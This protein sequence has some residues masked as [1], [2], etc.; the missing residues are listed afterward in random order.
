V[1]MRRDRWSLD[2]FDDL[3]G[4]VSASPSPTLPVPA[5]ARAVT[6]VAESASYA[7]SRRAEAPLAYL[8]PV[9]ALPAV[10]ELQITVET[11][12]SPPPA[13]HVALR[14]EALDA[15]LAAFLGT[16]VRE[17]EVNG[18]ATDIA[19]GRSAGQGSGRAAHHAG[20]S[21]VELYLPATGIALADPLQPGA[22]LAP[23]APPPEIISHRRGGQERE[24]R[25]G[26]AAEVRN[27]SRTPRTH[28]V[29]VPAAAAA[30][31]ASWQA[32]LAAPLRPRA[33]PAAVRIDL[34]RASAGL[35]SEPALGTGPTGAA[36]VVPSERAAR[37]LSGRLGLRRGAE[38]SSSDDDDDGDNDDDLFGRARASMR[39]RA[40][41]ATPSSTRV[42]TPPSDMGLVDEDHS[43]SATSSPARRNSRKYTLHCDFLPCF[44]VLVQDGCKSDLAGSLSLR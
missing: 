32:G 2:A 17:A 3:V 15:D 33:Q 11:S 34:R 44:L 40:L 41:P 10:A 8:P 30:A 36:A 5:E 18:G 1:F 29:P 26:S 7:V 21:L 38:G 27:F 28:V 42:L 19:A 35:A 31:S 20:D 6:G 16:G 13:D 4:R 14:R 43:W 12:S 9:P 22:T 23:A 25:Q 37:A 24:A 39:P